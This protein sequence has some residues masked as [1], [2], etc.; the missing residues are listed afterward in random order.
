VVINDFDPLRTADDLTVDGVF[1]HNDSTQTSFQSDAFCSSISAIHTF[2][3][4]RF[5]SVLSDNANHGEPNVL[6]ILSRPFILC[7][8]VWIDLVSLAESCPS[9]GGMSFPTLGSDT[10]R[11]RPELLRL[12]PTCSSVLEPPAAVFQQSM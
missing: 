7:I 4:W 6:V 10:Y 9:R 3:A 1:G 11:E 12:I 5:N 8:R 2:A